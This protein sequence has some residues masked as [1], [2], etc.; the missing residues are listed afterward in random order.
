MTNWLEP[1]LNLFALVVGTVGFIVAMLYQR[2]AKDRVNAVAMAFFVF[3][4]SAMWGAEVF[5]V[6]TVVM[7][8]SG[9]RL[10]E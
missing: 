8:L 1:T 6:M 4:Q 3:M 7:R 9:H 5:Y 10:G 2:R